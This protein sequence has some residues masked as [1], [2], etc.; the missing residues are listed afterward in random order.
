MSIRPVRIASLITG[1]LLSLGVAFNGIQTPVTFAP[2]AQLTATVQ[3]TSDPFSGLSI[4]E[5]AARSYGGGQVIID[6][7]LTGTTGFTRYFIHYPSDGLAIY[8]FMDVPTAAPRKGSAYPVIIALHGYIDPSIYTTLDYTTGYAD[9]LARAGYLVLH[10]DLRNYG[11]SD[12][13]PNL[14]RVGFAIDVLNLI[15]IVRTQGGQPGP[16]QAANPAAI[17]LWGHSMGGGISIRVMTVD[18][19]IRAVVLGSPISGDDKLN[20]AHFLNRPGQYDANFPDALFLRASPMYFYDRVQAAVSI[21][22]G[23]A[24]QTVPPAWSAD[25]CARLKALQKSVECFTYPGQPHTFVGAGNQLFIQRMIAFFDTY[26][27]TP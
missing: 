27:Q 10:P 16:L 3:A 22:Q 4:A 2:S 13:G 7:T 19:Q 15:A 23:L 9:A 6:Q 11:P 12:K 26:L 5:L 25:L 20:V 21:H 18:P 1:S 8:G 17:G 24:D 14:L